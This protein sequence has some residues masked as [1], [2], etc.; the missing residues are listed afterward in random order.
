[1]PPSITHAC[2][3]GFPL[4]SASGGEL[5]CAL[6]LAAERDPRDE[7]E[8]HSVKPS[9]TNDAT[10]FPVEECTRWSRRS[11]GR[12]ALDQA[13]IDSMSRRSS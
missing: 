4:V 13:A 8:P 3:V 7:L 10:E 2:S 5:Q 9:D 12:T 11:P 6:A 1:V